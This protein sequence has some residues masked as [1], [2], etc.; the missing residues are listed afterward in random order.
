MLA[1]Q[2]SFRCVLLHLFLDDSSWHVLL[3]VRVGVGLAS[4]EHSTQGWLIQC[5]QGGCLGGHRAK[6][7][8]RDDWLHARRS[9]TKVLFAKRAEFN[10]LLK[11]DRLEDFTDEGLPCAL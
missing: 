8:I 9:T 10:R 4:A 7:V 6:L 11:V 1:E 5:V 2:G 3:S